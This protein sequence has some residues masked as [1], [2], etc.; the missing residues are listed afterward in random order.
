MTESKKSETER[1]RLAKLAELDRKPSPNPKYRGMFVS[2]LEL[3]AK[4][5]RRVPSF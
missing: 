2:T 3:V 1:K 4:N 5:R